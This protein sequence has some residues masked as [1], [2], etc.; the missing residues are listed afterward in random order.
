MD[1][2]KKKRVEKARRRHGKEMEIS[3]GVWARENRSDVEAELESEE[4]TELG[5]DVSS[6]KDGDWDVVATSSKRRESAT[7]SA[8]GE[9]VAG[10][11]DDVPP[12][13]KRAASSDAAGEREVKR[14]RSPR[15]L[16]ASPASPAL[17]QAW[18]G[19][20]ASRRSMPIPPDLW[21]QRARASYNTEMP[22]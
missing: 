8:S 9:R 20:L 11:R 7:T 10:R 21:G 6:S 2:K 12:S 16:E 3:R 17:L 19:A 1:A 4:P 15:P 18:R 22:R 5:G 13:R 14:P